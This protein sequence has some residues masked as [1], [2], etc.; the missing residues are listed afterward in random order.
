MLEVWRQALESKGFKLSKTKTEYLECKFSTEPRKVRVEVRL[1]SQVI[2][3]SGNF[4][5]LGS[6]IHRGREIDEYVI[7]RIGVGCMKWR[8][9][10]RVLY[11]KRV[12]PI[13]RGK[14]YKAVVRPAMMYGVECWPI[15]NSHI[16]KMKVAEMRMLR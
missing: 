9:A 2:P 13:L 5:Y 16:R 8:L 15:K 10:Y 14:F 12:P 1:E 7:H 4:K 3:S 6:V 11:D